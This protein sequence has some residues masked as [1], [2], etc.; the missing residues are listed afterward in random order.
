MKFGKLDIN[1]K[2]FLGRIGPGVTVVLSVIY[3][4]KVYEAGYWYTETY[5]ILD[6]PEEIEKDIGKIEKY[7]HYNDIIKHLI[8][9]TPDYD[10]I[11]LDLPDI[12]EEPNDNLDKDIDIDVSDLDIED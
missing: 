3:N 2:D 12:F 8:E 6:I 7:E 9:I 11:A 5:N 10:E 1:I 4:T